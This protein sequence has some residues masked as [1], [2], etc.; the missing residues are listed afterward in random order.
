MV[1]HVNRKKQCDEKTNKNQSIRRPRTTKKVKLGN[2]QCN[3]Q[4]ESD[5]AKRS[6]LKTDSSEVTQRRPKP[7][8]SS[9][10]MKIMTK[11]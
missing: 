5:Q 11:S 3:Q 9:E 7:S 4:N 2:S 10:R 1:L 8:T 6:E